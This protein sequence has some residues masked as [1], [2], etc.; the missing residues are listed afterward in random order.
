MS[1]TQISKYDTEISLNSTEIS[2]VSTAFFAQDTDF[3]SSQFIHEAIVADNEENGIPNLNLLINGSNPGQHGYH[4]GEYKRWASIGWGAMYPFTNLELGDLNGDNFLDRLLNNDSLL[5][6]KIHTGDKYDAYGS[7]SNT[8]TKNFPLNSLIDV[9]LAQFSQ[10]DRFD[11]IT[12]TTP[13]NISGFYYNGSL[14]K[15][16]EFQ[17]TVAANPINGSL[18]RVFDIDNAQPAMNE[19]LIHG[20]NPVTNNTYIFLVRNQT[21]T[22]FDAN[23]YYFQLFND[24]L[25]KDFTVVDVN[26][27]SRKDVVA[28]NENGIYFYLQNASNEFPSEPSKQINGNYVKLEFGDLDGNDLLDL[29]VLDNFSLVRIFYDL[30]IS[31]APN[32][33]PDSTLITTGIATD[34]VIADLDDPSTWETDSLMDVGV[35]VKIGTVYKFIMFYQRSQVS[36]WWIW[37]IIIPPAVLIPIL[38]YYRRRKKK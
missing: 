4:I 7:S 26:E 17:L 16:D 27:D 35:V 25:F 24:T 2:E 5:Q 14:V 13:G 18:M 3:E 11:V 37:L 38:I 10:N 30:E 15:Y 36:A 28:V 12:L 29:V 1:Y 19:V 22:T 6:L 9:K 34:F 8:T 32:I 20:I 31:Q 33:N 23:P 21:A